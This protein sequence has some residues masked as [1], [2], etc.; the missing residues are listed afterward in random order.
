MN[1]ENKSAYANTFKMAEEDLD[2][3]KSKGIPL[4]PKDCK[5]QI[6]KKKVRVL[7]SVNKIWVCKY[8][9]CSDKAEMEVENAN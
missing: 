8:V 9:A 2:F 6:C 3:L 4:P 5:C 7:V 1:E